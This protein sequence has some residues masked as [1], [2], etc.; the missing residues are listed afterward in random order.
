V[1]QIYK[2]GDGTPIRASLGPLPFG[3]LIHS[4]PCD[5]VEEDLVFTFVKPTFRAEHEETDYN[6]FLEIEE[7]FC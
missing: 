3:V 4:G 1:D 6:T 5:Q 2:Y 7:F